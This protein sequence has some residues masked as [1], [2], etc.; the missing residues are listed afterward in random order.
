MSSNPPIYFGK[1]EKNANSVRLIKLELFDQLA[2]FWAPGRKQALDS[3]IRPPRSTGFAYK[4]NPAGTTGSRPP[5]FPTVLAGVVVDGEV[6][7]TAVAA[8]TNAITAMS[9]PSEVAFVPTGAL[10]AGTPTIADGEATNSRIEVML[11]NDGV[12]GITY[13]ASISVA[14]GA[15]TLIC[16]FDVEIL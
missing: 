10:T 12:V 2:S 9:A 15:Q 4:A 8:G 1:F 13:R 14:V 5:T 11:N 3:H 7:W 16:V 6:T